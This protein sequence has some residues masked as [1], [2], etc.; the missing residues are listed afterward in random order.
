MT[1]AVLAMP[2]AVLGVADDSLKGV[3]LTN[4]AHLRQLEVSTSQVP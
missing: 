1:N 3:R 2:W 4:F